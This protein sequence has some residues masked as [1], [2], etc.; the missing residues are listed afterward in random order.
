MNAPI[1]EVMF[2]IVMRFGREHGIPLP[3]RLLEIG[4]KD[5]G[6][7]VSLN[8]TKEPIGEVKPG[9]ALVLWRGIPV[10]LVDA[11]GGTIASGTPANEDSLCEWLEADGAVEHHAMPEASDA[12]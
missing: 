11:G 3:K 10:G 5:D 12:R 8:P 6:W 7:H 1:S 9:T 4:D 2:L